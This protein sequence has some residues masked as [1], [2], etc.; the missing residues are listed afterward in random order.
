MCI[1]WWCSAFCNVMSSAVSVLCSAHQRWELSGVGL[2][3]CYTLTTLHGMRYHDCSTRIGYVSRW[4]AHH[5]IRSAFGHLKHLNLPRIGLE[6]ESEDDFY[7]IPFFDLSGRSHVVHSVRVGC[8]WVGRWLELHAFPSE[9]FWW[10]ERV[11]HDEQVLIQV[12]DNHF[13]RCHLKE[14]RWYRNP[15]KIIDYWIS[16]RLCWYCFSEKPR[17]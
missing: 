17:E 11:T 16:K 7:F 3:I 15:K 5:P 6:K 8:V 9:D 10:S 13:S 14:W 2:V 4:R 1:V 12:R